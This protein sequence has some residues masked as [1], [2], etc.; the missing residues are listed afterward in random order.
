MILSPRMAAVGQLVPALRTSSTAPGALADDDGNPF[1][2]E[3]DQ[4]IGS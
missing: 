3:V 4:P 1:F 2:I